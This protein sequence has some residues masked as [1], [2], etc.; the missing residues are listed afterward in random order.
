MRALLIVSILFWGCAM[1]QGLSDYEPNPSARPANRVLIRSGRVTLKVKDIEVFQKEVVQRVQALQGWVETSD[2][3]AHKNVWLKV[4]I[5]D[6]EL[7]ATMAWLG[8]LGTI[9]SRTLS[10]ED[11][12]DQLLDLET[13]LRNLLLLRERYQ[14]LLNQAKDVKDILEI[15]KELNRIQTEIEQ[16]EGKLKVLKQRVAMAS[17]QIDA[18]QKR[19]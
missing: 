5:P 14:S 13:R 3:T 12:T 6:S 2:V 16:L 10:T 7:E 17:L 18:R 11:V 4:R 9:K 8:Q 15:E 1:K 19:F